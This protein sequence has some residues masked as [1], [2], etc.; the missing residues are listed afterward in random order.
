MH[1]K[2]SD[3][4]QEPPAVPRIQ[5]SLS[6]VSLKTTHSPILL[7]HYVL[8]I[9]PLAGIPFLTPSPYFALL[10][11]SFCFHFIVQPRCHFTQEA[12]ADTFNSRHEN[13]RHL[14]YGPRASHCH[15]SHFLVTTG[16]FYSPHKLLKERNYAFCDPA[17]TVQELADVGHS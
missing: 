12:F 13:V 16:R 2:K 11:A 14:F 17:C 5:S 8:S 3:R 6:P 10:S 4:C 7:N 15:S 1:S 9:Y